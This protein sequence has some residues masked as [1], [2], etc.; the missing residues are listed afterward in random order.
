MSASVT[1][2][3]KERGK[4]ETSMNKQNLPI[5]MDKFTP[6]QSMSLIVSSIIG[7]GILVLPR[8]TSQY[9]KQQGWITLVIGLFMTLFFTWVITKL[10]T[11]IRGRV[12]ADYVIQILSPERY[13]WMGKLMGIPLILALAGVW[14]AV[15]ALETRAFGAV[16]IT[17]VLVNT[18]LEV[19]IASMLLVC[20]YLCMKKEIVVARVNEFLIPL[21]IVPILILALF[22]LKHGNVYRLLPLF[23]IETKGFLPS[24][25]TSLF[26]FLGFDIILPFAS[27]YSPNVRY[28]RANLLGIAIVGVLYFLIVIAGLVV[29]GF[30]ELQRLT[31]PTLELVKTVY[32][33]AFILERLE[34]IFIGFWVTAIFTTAANYY[35]AAMKLTCDLFHIQKSYYVALAFLP[36]LYVIAMYPRNLFDLLAYLERISWIWFFMSIVLP[37]LLLGLSF[38]RNRGTAK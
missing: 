26:A 32:V 35:Y 33:P 9:L 21:I 1:Q 17:A 8:T 24:V 2:N 30:E 13:P 31:W 18:P 34:A 16:V 25:T 38:L 7:F 27:R 23:P 29:F 19:I 12:F 4:K 14:L 28:M 10:I 37:A 22:S 15:T 6:S 20:L 11:Y 5:E 36:V 3:G